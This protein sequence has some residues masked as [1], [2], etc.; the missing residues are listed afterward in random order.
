MP[1]QKKD[2]SKIW[3]RLRHTY[4]LVVMNNE[5]FEE[6]GSYRLTLLN[7]Y[8]WLSTLVVLV[9]IIVVLAIFY[10]P[11]RRYVPGYGKINET[12]ELYELN[13]QLAD[14]ER[15]FKEQQT[16]TENF[17]KMLIGEFDIPEE[18]MDAETALNY[19][20]SIKEVKRIEEDEMLRQEYELNERLRSR[21]RSTSINFDNV[22]LEQ[23]YFTPP[24]KGQISAG[25][26]PEKKHYGVDILGP[27][28]TP[29]KAA[30]DGFIITADWFLE[31]GHTI[32]IQHSNNIITFYKH[33]SALLKKV[34]ENVKA[35]EAVA[36]IGNSGT[37]SSG[38]HLHFEIWQ[39]GK[40]VNPEDFVNFD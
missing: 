1:E 25:F 20:D 8:I 9:A 23:I 31:T 38:P 15:Q 30:L 24:M 17:R 6:I 7:V 34:G 39:N 10:T 36:I 32:A 33:N 3:D 11:L 13:K 21:Q 35:G 14:M 16:Y 26:M 18:D 37:L 29:I 2:K 19:V 5:T 40:P 4:R 27:K 22:P 28:N 12:S